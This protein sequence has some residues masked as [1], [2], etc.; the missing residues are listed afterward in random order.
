MLRCLGFGM[1]VIWCLIIWGMEVVS[2]SKVVPKTMLKTATKV[3]A[4][5]LDTLVLEFLICQGIPPEYAKSLSKVPSATFESLSENLTTE[6]VIPVRQQ[7][8]NALRNSMSEASNTSNFEMYDEPRKALLEIFT[9]ENAPSFLQMDNDPE[10]FEAYIR[11]ILEQ[12]DQCNLETLPIEKIATQALVS[13][14]KAIQDDPSLTGL[15]T[16]INT[17]KNL[18]ISS[19]TFHNT[20]RIIQMLGDLKQNSPKMN[21]FPNRNSSFV[22][23]DGKMKNTNI[24][25]SSRSQVTL[26]H[27]KNLTK[28]KSKETLIRWLH[29]SDLHYDPQ[30]AGTAT[31]D[32]HRKFQEYV[33][34]K[35]IKVDKIF[36]TGDFRHAGRQN[37]SDATAKAAVDFLRDIAKHVGV[38]KDENIHIVPG[39][40]DLN[41]GGNPEDTNN[42]ERKKLDEVYLLYEPDNGIFEGK[43]KDSTLCLNYLRSRFGFFEKCSKQ[44]H[45]NIWANFQ[46]GRTHR[47]AHYSGYS[48]LYLNT[49]L[50]SGR[51]EK[52]RGNLLIGHNDIYDLLHEAIEQPSTK[53]IIICAHHIINDLENREYTKIKN[54]LND[55]NIPILWLCGDVHDTKYNNSYNVAYITAGCMLKE[56]G[57]GASFFVGRLTN[58]FKVI[59]EAHGYDGN[60]LGWQPAEAIS[61]RIASSLPKSLQPLNSNALSIIK[62][63]E[64]KEN[65][66]EEKNTYLETAEIYPEAKYSSNEL[67]YYYKF[68]KAKERELGKNHPYIANIY[69][70]IATTHSRQ[71]EYSEALEWHY[72]ALDIREKELGKNHL[73][74][75]STYFWIAATYSKQGDY[76]KA[77]EWHYKALGIR[78]RILGKDHP[79]TANIYN[80][81]AYAY[82]RLK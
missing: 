64:D 40:H 74:T 6:Q 51:G 33:S 49:A 73:D 8:A 56:Q 63:V 15:A 79:D 43:I 68:L 32:L 48:I 29:I 58:D 31:K 75:A 45:N 53:I 76:S 41:C 60:N 52:D 11:K 65:F 35:N 50:A 44:L 26:E 10:K 30:N 78:E 21:I 62:Q 38:T 69:H 80:W 18:E 72:K 23:Y 22:S 37:D 24:T 70:D 9:S 1:V 81:I 54:I 14:E 25:S 55:I 77:L 46:N 59:I 71:K 27:T 82:S 7:L 19:A 66:D 4:T 17:K 34:E 57:A 2:M 12:F 36:F 5:A 13:L 20:E 28:I 3:L 67:H 39:N 42:P 47:I 61:R 16:Y